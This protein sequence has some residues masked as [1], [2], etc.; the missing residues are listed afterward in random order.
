MGWPLWGFIGLCVVV[1]GGGGKRW[2]KA[3][4]PEWE[5]G[6]FSRL[7][8]VT[9]KRD[10]PQTARGSRGQSRFLLGWWLGALVRLGGVVVGWG[11]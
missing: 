2:A 7:R 10:S 6:E 11:V 1:I 9:Q 3:T 8:W 4:L 5:S